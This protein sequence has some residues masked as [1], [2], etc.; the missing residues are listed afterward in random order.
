MSD[1]FDGAW[2]VYI[3]V[4]TVAGLV[5]C[6]FA[7]IVSR[8]VVRLLVPV[9]QGEIVTPDLTPDWTVVGYALVLAL[10]CTM[11]VTLGP[12]LRTWRQ[13]LLPFL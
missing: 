11:A 12:A 4:V 1:F 5:A 8:M 7:W 10:F 3:A 9:A 6:L 2:S 13:Q